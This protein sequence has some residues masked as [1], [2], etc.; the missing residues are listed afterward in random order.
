MKCYRIKVTIKDPMGVKK[1]YTSPRVYLFA[2]WLI[3]PFNQVVTDFQTKCE[4]LFGCDETQYPPETWE[5]STK[6]LEYDIRP[7]N[8][9]IARLRSFLRYDL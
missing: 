7:L 2:P 1:S 8:D 3:E 6:Y 9:L 4:L 5:T